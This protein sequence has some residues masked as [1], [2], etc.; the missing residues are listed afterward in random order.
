[1]RLLLEVGPG[2]LQCDTRVIAEFANHG[3]V[4]IF[5][6]TCWI[7]IA[8]FDTKG[9]ALRCQLVRALSQ[10]H[11]IEQDIECGRKAVEVRHDL[12][13]GDLSA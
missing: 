10:I 13:R 6:V 9:L 1:M 8:E 3:V 2:N 5:E 11:C 4:S 7:T 12:A